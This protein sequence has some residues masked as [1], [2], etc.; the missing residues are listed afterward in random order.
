MVVPVVPGGDVDD[1]QSAGSARCELEQPG[2]QKGAKCPRCNPACGV[3]RWNAAKERYV[4]FHRANAAGERCP[5]AGSHG[6]ARRGPGPKRDSAPSCQSLGPARKARRAMPEM[7]EHEA[8]DDQLERVLQGDELLADFHAPESATSPDKYAQTK[9]TAHAARL[10]ARLVEAGALVAAKHGFRNKALWESFLFFTASLLRLQPPELLREGARERLAD[11]ALE[12]HEDDV[13]AG[14]CVTTMLDMGWRSRSDAAQLYRRFFPRQALC[15]RTLG[16]WVFAL[17]VFRYPGSMEFVEAALRGYSGAEVSAAFSKAIGEDEEE[18]LLALF[19][20]G[21]QLEFTLR[22]SITAAFDPRD[23]RRQVYREECERAS[24]DDKRG[25]HMLR[26]MRQWY[27]H[28][29]AMATAV[30]D[31]YRALAA[32]D[33]PSL[34]TACLALMGAI[35]D[36]ELLGRPFA[37]PFLSVEEKSSCYYAKFILD[38]IYWLVGSACCSSGENRDAGFPAGGMKP[39]CACAA[40][41]LLLRARGKHMFIGPALRELIVSLRCPARGDKAGLVRGVLGAAQDLLPDFNSLFLCDLDLY[42]LQFFPCIW[43]KWLMAVQRLSA[44]LPADSA[45]H[46]VVLDRLRRGIRRREKERIFPLETV[47][48]RELW[49]GLRRLALVADFL[50]APAAQQ[51]RV[52]DEVAWA[53]TGNLRKYV[54]DLLSH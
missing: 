41:R 34:G 6:G 8:A 1:G 18:T 7:V 3:N 46:L 36:L 47:R 54:S 27:E 4:P 53:A 37:D 11:V 12:R 43:G 17:R 25:D 28:A 38:S 39:R 50:A 49:G 48:I 35:L 15:E 33:G 23:G 14:K 9:F 19:T 16:P 26:A 5:C 40:S 13:L 22:A 29:P 21:L 42:A 44:A 31:V 24:P 32:L 2:A 30:M 52:C 51:R 10:P 20:E 45:E